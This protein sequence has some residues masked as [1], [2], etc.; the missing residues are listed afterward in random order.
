MLGQQ[1]CVGEYI[2][3]TKVTPEKD[4]TIKKTVT[5]EKNDPSKR[6]KTTSSYLQ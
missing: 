2:Q 3:V 6:I 4:I 5:S 1:E